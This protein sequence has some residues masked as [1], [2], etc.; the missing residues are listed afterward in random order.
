MYWRKRIN[1]NQSTKLPPD[2]RKITLTSS[3][4]SRI[5][6][7]VL[8][9]KESHLSTAESPTPY[10]CSLNAPFLRFIFPLRRTKSLT[11]SVLIFSGLT[12][13][14]AASGLDSSFNT[15]LVQFLK[16]FDFS[17]F[18]VSPSSGWS[19]LVELRNDISR[20][21][22]GCDL[23]SYSD[24]NNSTSSSVATS[25]T[26]NVASTSTSTTSS[27]DTH[28]DTAS[29][30]TRATTFPSKS[31]N[32]KRRVTFELTTESASVHEPPQKKKK[33][34]TTGLAEEC[35]EHMSSIFSTPPSHSFESR[36][37]SRPPSPPSQ[38][39]LLH[40]RR[41]PHLRLPQTQRR[42]LPRSPRTNEGSLRRTERTRP[43][44]QVWP[45][46]VLGFAEEVSGG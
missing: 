28:V 36:E 25:T 4:N 22:T 42:S 15:G 7:L 6:L 14:S 29:P 1:L 8:P 12:T 38:N 26:S 2:R 39:K 20:P 30:I 23:E 46:F 41:S 13:S 18:P 24:A 10:P 34:R 35:G 3:T 27:F 37:H 9:N 31:K 33:T 45:D 19:E 11:G 32:S 5:A 16:S 21:E 44:R 43:N 17:G 40:R